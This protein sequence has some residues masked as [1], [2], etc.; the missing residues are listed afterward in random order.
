MPH[1][2]D[3]DLERYHLGMISEDAELAKIEEQILACA[4]CA[5]RAEQAADYVDLMR[6]TIIKG[7]FD[8]Q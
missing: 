1:I 6:R 5:E 3:D 2:S 4:G 8:L 7:D